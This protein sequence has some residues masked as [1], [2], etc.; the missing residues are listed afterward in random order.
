MPSATSPR[1]ELRP[2]LIACGL[3]TS[4][5]LPPFLTGAVAVEM[6]A[7]LH[8]SPT[9]L[10]VLVGAYFV[11][12]ALSSG[13]GG[14]LVERIGGKKG[15]RLSAALA[16]TSLLGI[17]LVAGTTLVAGVF[18]LFGG[19]SNGVAQ[20]A[21]NL[22]LARTIP[23]GRHGLVFGIKQSAIPV[24]TSLAGLSV[25][26]VALTVGWR[27]TFL[28]G[29]LLALTMLVM[30]L[31][32]PPGVA[33][34]PAGDPSLRPAEGATTGMLVLLAGAVMLGVWGGQ[35]LGAFLVSSSVS[36]GMA[37]SAAGMLLTVGSVAGVASRIGMG[38][39]VDRTAVPGLRLIAVMM[40]VGV[41]GFGAIGS[42]MPV[43][44]WVG[45]VLAFAGGWG[46]SGLL[47]Y[48][49]VRLRPDAP[50]KATGITQTGLFAAATVGPPLFGAI[51]EAGSYSVAWFTTSVTAAV[52]ALLVL[53]IDRRLRD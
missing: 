18:M 49:V 19:A 22:Y 32:D 24:A 6:G 15:M 47:T 25:P 41:V 34:S 26:L 20:T 38:W 4:A 2:V 29:G 3:V 37:Q 39:L 11:G 45:P 48:A 51:A 31:A 23:P 10:G 33:G 1:L 35:S 42:G 16:L 13:P 46:W 9:R 30:P 21:T 14:H 43:L 40:G 53:W 52:A 50:A 17:G 44:L 12:A 8:L 28:A 27:Y 36:A 7:E 5:A